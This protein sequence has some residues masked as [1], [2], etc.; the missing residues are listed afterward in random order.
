MTASSAAT[1]F[2]HA[3]PTV[4]VCIGAYNRAR[5]IRACIDSVLTQTRPADEVIVVDDASTDG[6]CEILESYGDRIILI[7]R[8]TNSGICPI[9]RNQA[10]Q[11][12][13]GELIAFLD[14]DDLWYPEKLTRQVAFMERHSEVPLCHTLCDV[15]DAEGKVQHVRHGAEVVPP[16]GYCFEALLHHCWITISMVMVRRSLFDEIGWF[17]ADPPYG[18]LGEDQEFFLRVARR[19]PIGFIPEVLGGFR[20]AGQG[21]TASNWKAIPAAVPLFQAL[22]ERRDIW[23]GKVPRSVMVKA[24]T[25]KCDRNAYFY[26]DNKAWGRAAW[27]ARQALKADWRDGRAWRHWAASFLH[28]G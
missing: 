3:G 9:T 25:D 7:K 23:E 26:R 10:A 20:K 2:G 4:S 14:S 13:T 5:D 17:N 8:Q 27:F 18:Y 15:I 12:A 22:L 19:Y 16:T 21:I 11:A 28:R 6:T 1:R 24:L